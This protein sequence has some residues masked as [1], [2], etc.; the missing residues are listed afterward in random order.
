MESFE[1][2]RAVLAKVPTKGKITAQQIQEKLEAEGK[3]LSLRTVQRILKSLE[4]YGVL[5]DTGKP[6]GWSREQG[7][8]LGLTKMDLSTA[9]TL[10][11]AE[12]YLEQAFPPSLLRNLE[13]HFNGARFYLRY[14]NKTPQGLWPRKVYIH[15]KGM[16]LLP[17]K[18]AAETINVIYKAVLEEKCIRLVYRSMSSE[19]E[20][21]VLFHPY[22]IVVRGERNYLVGKFEGYSDVRQLSFNRI[23]SAEPS[24]FP[25]IIDEDFSLEKYVQHGEMGVTRSLYKLAIKLWVTPVFA[26][27]LDETPLCEGQLIEPKDD[28]FLVHASV[29][30]TDELRHWLLSVCNH[31]TVLEPLALRDEIK[32]TLRDSLSWYED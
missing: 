18:L 8:D 22:G 29:D 12:K 17:S 31:A 6:I 19:K 14:E 2:K 23:I 13:S 25:A 26:R 11:L 28:D 10:N 32:Q 30:D 3:R 4:K 1:N 27:I 21:R 24:Y 5:S 20:Q 15:Q 16:P 7:L 9:I